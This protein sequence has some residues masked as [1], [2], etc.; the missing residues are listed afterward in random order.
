MPARQCGHGTRSVHYPCRRVCVGDTC[1]SGLWM[2]TD[3]V[4]ALAA[5]AVAVLKFSTYPEINN[6]YTHDGN[7]SQSLFGCD[8]SN[9][10]G[11]PSCPSPAAPDPVMD[12]EVLSVARRW[13]SHCR[14]VLPGLLV[15]AAGVTYT[16]GVTVVDLTASISPSLIPTTSAT[17][18]FAIKDATS[19]PNTL[20]AVGLSMPDIPI[21]VG[22]SATVTGVDGL[23]FTFL[24]AAGHTAGV[25]WTVTATMNVGFVISSA[26]TR[27]YV[28]CMQA[29]KAV[30][31]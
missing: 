21:V 27:Q 25:Q 6:V 14:S 15:W 9:L 23:L 1:C 7:P 4:Q 20:T 26:P 19:V 30:V 2:C 28:L 29:G 3:A 10:A 11:M 18:T 16:C 8:K 17:Y 31:V 24:S 12:V 22:A 5:S 13:S